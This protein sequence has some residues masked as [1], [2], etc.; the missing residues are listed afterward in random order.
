MAG[1]AKDAWN[2]VSE[3]F[4]SW[5]RLVAERY[6][7]AQPAD[8]AET[9][10]GAQAG[11]TGGQERKLDEAA[12]DLT[13]QL[14][15]AFTAV[16]ETLRDA[17]AKDRLKEAVKALGDAVSVTVTETTDEVRKRLRTTEPPSGDAGSTPPP[18]SG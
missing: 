9:G 17:E 14:N 3:R 7:E 15:R 6:R 4:T 11:T 2:D 18:P 1:T 12:R 5:G 8:T 16:G 13:E 10:E